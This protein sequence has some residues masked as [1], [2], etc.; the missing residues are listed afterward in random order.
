M[1]DQPTTAHRAPRE[2][3]AG[4]RLLLVLSVLLVAGAGWLLVTGWLARGQLLDAE[5]ALGRARVAAVD[6]HLPEAAD[7][8]TNAQRAAHRSHQLTAGP[9]WGAVGRLPWLGR[10]PRAVSTAAR[11][12]DRLSS[13]VLPVLVQAAE[14]ASPDRLRTSGTAVNLA[15]LARVA[16]PLAAAAARVDDVERTLDGTGRGSGVLSP[17]AR[18]L[19]Q[20]RTAVAGLAAA[21]P[22]PHW[23]PSWCRRCWGRT[24]HAPICWPSRIRPNRGAPVGSS[25]ATA[26]SRQ[27]TASSP[28]RRSGQTPS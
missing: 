28:S 15:P 16:P 25:A 20:F 17:V 26:S 8:V 23:P 9:V 22:A 14:T 2:R 6:Q 3:F 19:D 5:R 11:E 21:V 1:A 12:A 7:Q 10:T 13:D 24:D 27:T 18:G 4:G